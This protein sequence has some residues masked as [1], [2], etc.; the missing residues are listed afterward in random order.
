M[1]VLV[2]LADDIVK[3]VDEEAKSYGFKSR[4]MLIEQVLRKH[5]GLKS[6]LE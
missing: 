1:K 3:K 4:S 6:L 5:L 2:T